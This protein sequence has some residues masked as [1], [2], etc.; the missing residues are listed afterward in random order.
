MGTCISPCQTPDVLD[1]LAKTASAIS[2]CVSDADCAPSG[3][4]CVDASSVRG[5]QITTCSD[6]TGAVVV[7]AV[8]IKSACILRRQIVEEKLIA[9]VIA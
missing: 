5:C 6:T 1:L 9:S 8:H 4:V 2:P 3:Q 7:S